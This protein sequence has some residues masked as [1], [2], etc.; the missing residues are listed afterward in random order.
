MSLSIHD[1]RR[2]FPGGKAQF[3]S[4]M[5][6]SSSD[7]QSYPFTMSHI[8]FNAAQLGPAA[9]DLPAS[10]L[11][12]GSSPVPAGFPSP[13]EDLQEEQL[14]L[15]LRLVQRPSATFF[16]RVDGDS[17]ADAGIMHGAILVVDRSLRPKVGEIVVAALNDGF[18]CK[19][20]RLL[21]GVPYLV[22]E[23][24]SMAYPAIMLIEDEGH[25]LWGVVLS[26]INEFIRR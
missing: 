23:N 16:M 21:G 18:V 20:L 13:A 17:M 2:E 14:D 25:V 8:E 4:E 6:L 12:M 3:L 15:N 10:A 19:R 22:S 26:A 1:S 11:P 24:A 5:C 7:G 9:S